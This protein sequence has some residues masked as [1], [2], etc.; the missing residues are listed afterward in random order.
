VVY[1]L[2]IV[3]EC[4]LLCMVLSVLVLSEW[5][6]GAHIKNK[7]LFSQVMMCCV[8]ISCSSCWNVKVYMY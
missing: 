3:S 4:C 7:I 5:V 2:L 6:C 8:V 1:G